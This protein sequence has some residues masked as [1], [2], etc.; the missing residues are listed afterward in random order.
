MPSLYKSATKRAR[1]A[2]MGAMVCAKKVAS[3]IP[4]KHKNTMKDT[5][6]EAKIRENII[7]FSPLDL[8]NYMPKQAI[9]DHERLKWSNAPL[10][11]R[12]IFFI[13]KFPSD[14]TLK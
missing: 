10:G 8:S 9:W 6:F 4:P 11:N 2:N 1:A 5:E 13:P 14:R 12:K 7:L 3:I